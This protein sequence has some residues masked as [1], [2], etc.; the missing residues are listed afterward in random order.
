M[1]LVMIRETSEETNGISDIL[2][3]ECKVCQRTR[4]DKNSHGRCNGIMDV[5]SGM[6]GSLL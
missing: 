6:I 4:T 3:E 5:A 2:Q 1:L